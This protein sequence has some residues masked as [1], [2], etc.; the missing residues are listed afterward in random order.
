MVEE[1]SGGEDR[2]CLDVI[3]EGE[4]R[5]NIVGTLMAGMAEIPVWYRADTEPGLGKVSIRSRKGLYKVSI[6]V[7][8]YVRSEADW[9]AYA[10]LERGVLVTANP[11]WEVG[12]RIGNEL[13]AT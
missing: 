7:M 6:R 2:R 11:V 4:M 9:P 5:R 13:R 8:L 3:D 10:R 1:R 12:P